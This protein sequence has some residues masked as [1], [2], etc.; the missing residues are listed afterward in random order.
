MDR[1][2]EETYEALM[3]GADD[4]ERAQ[5]QLRLAANKLSAATQT[6]L[7]LCK[8]VSK[9]NFELHEAFNQSFKFLRWRS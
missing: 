7:L 1:L 3:S 5:R 2:L 8:Y 4:M 6:I 9:H